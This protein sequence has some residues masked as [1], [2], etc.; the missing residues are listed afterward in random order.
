M[1]FTGTADFAGAMTL[2][3]RAG[4]IILAIYGKS[5]YRAGLRAVTQS[6]LAISQP[7]RKRRISLAANLSCPNC[8]S[9]MTPVVAPDLTTDVCP[10]CGGMFLDKS[11]LNSLATGMAGDIELCSLDGPTPTDTAPARRCPR[12]P[13]TS[14]QKVSLLSCLDLALDFCPECHGFY[15]EKGEAAQINDVLCAV[16]H[17]QAGMEFRG[18]IDGRLVRIDTVSGTAIVEMEPGV[19]NTVIPTVSILATVFLKKPLGLGLRMTPEKW[20]VKLQKLVGL[21]HGQDI[22]VGA[23]A[24]DAAYVIEGEDETGIEALLNCP[25]A[26]HALVELQRNKPQIK[27]RP[28]TVT[29]LDDRVQYI[30][31]PYRG[32]ASQVRYDPVTDHAGVVRRLLNLAALLERA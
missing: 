23:H 2:P 32:E 26:R 12:C 1:S 22:N 21:F 4:P 18:E 14:M 11:E 10:N 25:D 6:A 13:E 16:M 24:L 30:E 19:T 15:L 29:V 9:E 17:A 27:S 31:G 20:T 5:L 3:W 7:S 28:G 8:G